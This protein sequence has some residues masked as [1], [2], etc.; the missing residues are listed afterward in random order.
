MED[1]ATRN[2]ATL[3]KLK[4]QLDKVATELPSTKKTTK[5]S[6]NLKI[7]LNESKIE[8]KKNKS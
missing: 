6:E 2:Q 4:A 8:M 3:N 5:N 1:L 7:E